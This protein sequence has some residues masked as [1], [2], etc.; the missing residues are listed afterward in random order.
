MKLFSRSRQMLNR[1]CAA[2]F[3]A[4]TILLPG[5]LRADQINANDFERSFT[6]KFPGY[7]G[8]ETLTDFPALVRLSAERNDFRYGKCPNGESLC[9]ADAA[10]NLIPH[11]I[12]TWDANG[13]SLVWVKVPSLNAATTI[14]AYYGWKGEGN[15]PVNTPTDVWSN[16]FVGVWHLGES[17]RPLRDSTATGIHFTSSF[18]EEKPAYLDDVTGYAESGGAIGKAVRFGLTCGNSNKDGRGGLLAYDPK[19]T[20]SGFSAMTLEIWAK[21]DS[22]VDT[23]QRYLVSK[24]LVN[25]PKTVV[26]NFYYNAPNSSGAQNAVAYFGYDNNGSYT[27]FNVSGGNMAVKNT[28]EWYYHVAQFDRTKAAN[29]NYLNGVFFGRQDGQ[30]DY[31]LISTAATEDPLCLGNQPDPNKANYF[32]GTLDELRISNVTRSEAWIKATYDTVNEDNFAFYRVPIDWKEYS[33]TFSVSFPGATNGVLSAF[34][35]LVKVSESSIPGFR[36][37]DCLKEDGGDLRFADANGNL[38]DSEIDTWNTNGV[39]LVWVNVPNFSSGTKLKAYYGCDHAPSVDSINVWTN[40]YVGVW[41]LGEVSLPVK[42]STIN[43]AHFTSEKDGVL[44]EQAG[45]VGSSVRF[46]NGDTATNSYLKADE[47]V[48]GKLDGFAAV[49]FEAWTCQYWHKESPAYAGYI[50]AKDR[51]TGYNSYKIF[52]DT[53]AGNTTRR[54][55][56]I[57]GLSNAVSAYGLVP[58]S[59]TEDIWNYQV[60]SYDSQSEATKKAAYYLNGVLNN[61]SDIGSAPLPSTTSPLYLGN[62]HG[63][64][65]YGYAFPG[66]IDE[67]RISNVARSAGWLAT[68]YDMIKGNADFSSYGSARANKTGTIIYYK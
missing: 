7:A 49:T 65:R 13:E 30:K 44:Y 61:T 39:S 34:P 60:F 6:I 56:Q 66:K 22:I 31:N 23:T 55:M 2:A 27:A 35:V 62:M 41:H 32:K 1:G 58:F 9:F 64:S 4:A 50:L 17:A 54:F 43:P 19:G 57:F 53:N 38:L 42:D 46:H 12:D 20:L 68:T 14:T 26:Y 21:P 52:E 11:E 47:S 37:A 10:G 36:Y 24:R 25:N 48:T 8:E 67:V 63:F 33:H 15:P 51:G 40:G 28:G 16:G 3:A 18:T 5:T 59:A 29:T 45:I